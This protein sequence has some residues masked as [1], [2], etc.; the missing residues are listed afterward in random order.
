MCWKCGSK[1]D[2]SLTISRS[3]T[4]PVCSS[5]LHSCRN[6]SFYSPGSHYDC[7]ETVDENISDKEKSNFCDYFKPAA[8]FSKTAGYEEKKE[9]AR[10]AFDALFS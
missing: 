2:T 9:K 3:S 6:C 8:S 7:H 4:C 1:I 10:A 5:D